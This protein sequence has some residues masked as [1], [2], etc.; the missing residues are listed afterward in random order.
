MR[1]RPH[2]PDDPSRSKKHTRKI[3][4]SDELVGGAGGQANAGR[5][6]KDRRDNT[7]RALKKKEK[8]VPMVAAR[9]GLARKSH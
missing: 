3:M 7:G 6:K 2:L 8:G 4:R 9:I 5:A 1:R